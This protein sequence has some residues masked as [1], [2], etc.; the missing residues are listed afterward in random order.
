MKQQHF[1]L[2]DLIGSFPLRGGGMVDERG[3]VVGFGDNN[4]SKQ[5]QIEL[6][7]WPQLVLIVVQMPFK[8]FWKLKFLQRIL[9]YPK[10]WNFGPT[11]TPIYLLEIPKIKDSHR[12]IQIN[13][14]QGPI[15]F[16]CSMKTIINFPSI[17]ASLETNR[18]SFKR[19]Q[20][21]LASRFQK[22][23]IKG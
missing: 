21:R 16:Q 11:L 1:L 2:Q 13:Q 14:N 20:L 19:L 23:L 6:S 10:F 12:I 17:C 8:G 18:P 5:R 15:S 4:S 22:P 3:F 7:F 9:K